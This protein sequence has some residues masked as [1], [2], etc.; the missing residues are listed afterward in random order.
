MPPARVKARGASRRGRIS[1]RVG[2]YGLIDDLPGLNVSVQVPR[3]FGLAAAGF[4]QL[5]PQA[6]VATGQRFD[7]NVAADTIAAWAQTWL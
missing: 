6:R 2:E 3:G 5:A 4:A 1:G 7:A